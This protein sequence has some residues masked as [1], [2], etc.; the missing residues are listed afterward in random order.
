[1]SNSSLTAL[2]ILREEYI[3]LKNRLNRIPT[4]LDYLEHGSIDPLIFSDEH[5]SYYHF[6]AKD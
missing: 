5:G 2:K 1:M 4:H 6:F 3:Q